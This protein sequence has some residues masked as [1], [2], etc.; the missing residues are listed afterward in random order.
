MNG[1]FQRRLM[2]TNETV[3]VAL[4]GYGYAGKTFHAPL[5]KGIPDFELK[6]VVSSDAKKVQTDLPDVS[7]C[8]SHDQVFSDENLDLV[9]IATPN[10]TH[11]DLAKR[12]L[13]T[14]KHVVVDKPFTTTCEEAEELIELARARELLLSVFHNRRWDAD[15]L[16]LR[17]LLAEG[18]LGDVMHFES[19][20]DR[21]RPEV[22]QRWREQA[23]VGS[24]IWFDLG[25]HLLD[26]TLQLFGEPESIQ[27]DL[28]QQRD[29]AQTVDFFHVILRYGKMRAILHASALVAAESPRFTVHG[30]LGSYVKFGLDTQEEALKRNDDVKGDDFGKDPRAGTLTVST[31][32]PGDAPCHEVTRETERGNYLA[33]YSGI[34]DAITKGASNPVPAE[35]ALNV[36][37]LLALGCK[38]S[39]AK[40]LMSFSS[41]AC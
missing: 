22:R 35:D 2:N 4:I 29:G 21:Y 28:E 25:S 24:G 3:N 39:E 14:G 36:M 23:G 1:Y 9:V 15:F 37:R 8:A 30:K 12:A 18:V 10:D 27:A 6:V 33:Y 40:R 38:S 31:A 17:K 26:Q 13:Q 16:T 7:V 41:E 5:I 11:F 19:H 32:P 20:F 34:R